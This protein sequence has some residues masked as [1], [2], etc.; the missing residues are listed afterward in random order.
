MKRNMAIVWIVLAAAL[1]ANAGTITGK[2]G[3]ASG[4]SVVYVEAPAGKPVTL[5]TKHY[6]MDQRE[7]QFQPHVLVVP[8]GATVDFQNSDSVGHNVFWPAISGNKSLGHNLGTWPQGEKKSFKFDKPGVVPLLC[9]VHP[10]MSGYLVV[11][12]TPYAAETDA[13]GNYRITDVP[14]GAYTV[15]AWHEGS[16]LQSKQISVAGDGKADFT[17][18]K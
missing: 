6:L 16:K 13:A 18:T 10:N 4:I 5:S 11:T 7:L 17:L 14:D 9:I 1:I 12:S 3:G 8:V 15:T 2:V